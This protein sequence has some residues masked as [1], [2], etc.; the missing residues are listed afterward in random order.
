MKTLTTIQHPPGSAPTRTGRGQAA[1]QGI[2]RVETG[3]DELDAAFET[4]GDSLEYVERLLKDRSPN[5][6]SQANEQHPEFPLRALRRPGARAAGSPATRPVL[7]GAT[8]CRT[9]DDVTDVFVANSTGSARTPGARLCR[10]GDA[11]DRDLPAGEPASTAGRR[12]SRPARAKTTLSLRTCSF[13]ERVGVGF[14]PRSVYLD[15]RLELLDQRY[16]WEGKQDLR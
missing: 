5:R 1:Q 4:A 9:E 7:R 11:D 13:I 15:G 14:L 8:L 16:P 6:G 2:P 12:A 3:N 10:V